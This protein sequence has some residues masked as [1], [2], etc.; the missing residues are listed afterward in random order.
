[1]LMLLLAAITAGNLAIW[2]IPVD[3]GKS[4]VNAAPN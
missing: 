4:L 1:M 3:S 2:L